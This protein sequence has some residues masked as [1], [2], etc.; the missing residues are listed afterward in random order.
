MKYV[1]YLLSLLFIGA[2]LVAR[3]E[4]DDP[5]VAVLTESNFDEFVASDLT[6]VEFYAPWCGHCKSLAPEYA[7]AATELLSHGI[8]LG[9]VDATQ[10]GKLAGRFSVSGYPT[11]KVFRN[12]KDF[13]YTGPRKAAGIVSYMKKQSGPAAK[14]LDTIA[15]VEAFI[16]SDPE[17]QYAI[18]GF[19]NQE[20]QQNSQLYSAFTVLS[21]RMRDSFVFGKV[22]DAQVAEHFGVQQDALVAFKGFELKEKDRRVVYEGDPS[23]KNVED[24]MRSNSLPLVGEFT[25]EKA[26]QYQK[27]DLP[28]AKLYLNFDPA[29]SPKQFDYYMNRLKKVAEEYKNKIL[30]TFAQMSKNERAVDEFNLK[31]KEYGLVIEQGWQDKYKFEDK[32]SLD[33]LRK[34]FAAF[35]AGKL[36]K[37]VRSEDVPADNSGPVTVV[38]GKTFE[39]IV[40]D[41][42]KDVLIEFYAPWCGHC[43]QLEPKYQE[44]G[45][46]FKKADNVVVAKIDATANDFPR[47]RY[48]VSGYPTIFFVPA[49]AKAE[50]RKYE[51]AREVS[52]MYKFIKKHAKS[53]FGDK[54]KKSKGKKEL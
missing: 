17:T 4:V 7:K 13:P 22:Y 23:T 11:L 3:A 26:D 50:P 9:K 35:D 19:F 31:G 24:W 49:K 5:D 2:V 44:L 15:D 10:E 42:T 40:E 16:K 46:K 52:A 47:E 14:Q 38:V 39:Q 53:S 20:K 30:F 37:H 48:Q 18:V 1:P 54:K 27:R 43:K 33:T 28:L 25:D 51:G 32:L 34:F 29:S 41:P 8:R 12:G 36:E 45:K 21:N 6:L